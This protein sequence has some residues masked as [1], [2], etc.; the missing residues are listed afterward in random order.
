MFASRRQLGE[1]LASLRYFDGRRR[2]GLLPVLV[3]VLDNVPIDK[4]VNIITRGLEF[5]A[6]QEKR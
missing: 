2:P 6:T 1:G 4:G 3:M 5:G